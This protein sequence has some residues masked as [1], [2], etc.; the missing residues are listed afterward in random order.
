MTGMGAPTSEG[1]RPGLLTR[2]LHRRRV[3]AALPHLRGNVL[4]HGCGPYSLAAYVAPEKY[5]GMDIDERCLALAGERHPA[6]R[7][8][9][10]VPNDGRYDTVASLAV[11]EHMPDPAAYLRQLA[12]FLGPN[13]RI[14]LTTP[15]PRRKRVYELGAKLRLFSPRASEE[16][17]R[18][19]DRQEIAGCAGSAGLRLSHYRTFLAGANQLAVLEATAAT[20]SGRGGLSGAD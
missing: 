19:L 1:L 15:H 4:D 7:F 13:G 3:G 18:L 16:H 9:T 10:A 17:G 14:V 5:L 12:S 8:V 11:I 2:F 6:H 20:A